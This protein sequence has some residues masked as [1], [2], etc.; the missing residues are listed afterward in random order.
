MTVRIPSPYGSM[1]GAPPE[2]MAAYLRD[3]RLA[4]AQRSLQ[5]GSSTAPLQGGWMEGLAR[6]GQGLLGGYQQGQIA[7]EYEGQAQNYRTTLAN[8][9]KAN[10]FKERIAVLGGN[11]LTKTA[12][13]DAMQEQDDRDAQLAAELLRKGMQRD[14]VPGAIKEVPGYSDIEASRAGN[15]SR[16]RAEAEG[17]A[18]VKYQ[19]QLDELAIALQKK[20]AEIDQRKDLAL[21]NARTA[22]EKDNIRL[23]A[24][25]EKDNA[26]ADAEA[27]AK[28]ESPSGYG[29]AFG[30]EPPRM[31]IDQSKAATYADRMATAHEILNN[32]DQVMISAG[33]AILN[34]IPES[35]GGNYV[36]SKEKQ[37]AEQAKRNF[38]NA[39]LRRESGAVITPSE[40][41]NAEQQYF[42]KPGDSPEVIEQKRQNR[43][44]QIAGFARE[45]GPA[46]K[47]KQPERTSEK[48]PDEYSKP[49]AKPP[50][51][52]AMKEAADAIARG[53]DRN[54][55]IERIINMGYDPTGL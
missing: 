19:P 53:A 11:D 4:M 33:Q 28:G 40:M 20:L 55:V 39:T 15:E 31:N 27:K 16:A 1:A 52:Q 47:R 37:L 5:E 51:E 2:L 32:L 25:L 44:E 6:L 24:Q 46:Y 10:T 50:Y 54:R 7:R 13:L 43:A 35:V 34:V 14:S 23:R 30:G 29:A 3:P 18:K 38:I 49:G 26:N 42:P 9:L 21:I 8:A 36:I 41:E 45:A 17:A 48:T 12:A 22:A